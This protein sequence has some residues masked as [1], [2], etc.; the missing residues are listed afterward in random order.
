MLGALWRRAHLEPCWDIQSPRLPLNQP[1]NILPTWKKERDWS[2]IVRVKRKMETNKTD[3]HLCLSWC[4]FSD[5]WFHLRFRRS[6]VWRFCLFFCMYIY[7]YI[8][9]GYPVF[10]M[11][12]GLR[13]WC[14]DI[15]DM[16]IPCF[17]YPCPPLYTLGIWRLVLC[18]LS[19]LTVGSLDF[20]G[21]VSLLTFG[22]ARVYKFH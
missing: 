14:V 11:F 9:Y 4:V 15:C 20:R 7:I 6:C 3:D 21:F 13:M 5:C 2:W 12:G 19:P 16:R 17:L 22:W 8:H 10:N 1:S 18:S